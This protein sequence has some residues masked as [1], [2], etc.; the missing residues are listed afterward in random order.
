MTSKKQIAANRKNAQKST[1]PR[2]QEGLSI[3]SQNALTYGITADKFIILQGENFEDYQVMQRQM[4]DDFQ[5]E[6]QPE[7]ALVKKM[8][9]ALWKKQR[10][11]LAENVLIQAQVM[12]SDLENARIQEEE[13]NNS[14]IKE[15]L[16]EVSAIRQGIEDLN[17]QLQEAKRINRIKDLNEFQDEAK[18]WAACTYKDLYAL[19]TELDSFL[20]WSEREDA[21]KDRQ[22]TEGGQYSADRWHRL[23][24]FKNT[25]HIN[26]E[27]EEGEEQEGENRQPIVK[28]INVI[29]VEG[30]IEELQGRLATQE[31]ELEKHIKS[32]ECRKQIKLAGMNLFLNETDSQKIQRYE[33]HLDNQYYKALS[34]LQKLQVFLIKKKE[35]TKTKN[36]FVSQNGQNSDVIDVDCES[37]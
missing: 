35:A 26:D 4:E 8:A 11:L 29:A 19:D 6:T 30:F 31:A 21:R 3:V 34:E 17:E 33:T 25:F 27:D 23:C 5:A 9:V 12:K 14:P 37:T 16:K 36:G 20:T 13:R 15:L 2:T 18:S 10:L 22:K 24:G 1:G 32:Q 28:P 7:K